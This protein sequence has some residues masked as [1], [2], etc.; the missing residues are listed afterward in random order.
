MSTRVKQARM[1]HPFPT[2]RTRK[3]I[4]TFL[5]IILVPLVL[6]IVFSYVAEI[7]FVNLIENLGISLW[8][9]FIATIIS[10]ILAWVSAV[11]FYRGRAGDVALP[12][13]DIL[14]SVP[15]AAAL[16]VAVMYFGATSKV[17][18]FFLVIAIIWPVFFS[19][20]S[21]LKLIRK[22]WYEAVSMTRIKGFDY[23]RYFL[24]PVTIPG[25][26]TGAIIGMG[27]GWESLVATEIIAGTESGLGHFFSAFSNNPSVTLFGILCV[28]AI[29]FALNKAMWLPLLEWSH[30]SMEE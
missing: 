26:V 30:R 11:V 29:I 23:L 18:I 22:D 4:L 10:V 24:I 19:I 2:L 13:F 12:I 14:Q 15:S 7:S 8:R 1:Y 9:M 20:I 16:P 27:E 3:H 21:S 17:V 28:L 5:F 25:L 6:L